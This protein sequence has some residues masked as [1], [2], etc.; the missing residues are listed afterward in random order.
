MKSFES[1]DL[2]KDL[3]RVR[4]FSGLV[5]KKI[6]ESNPNYEGKLQNLTKEE[7]EDLDKIL[8]MAEQILL[9]HQHK[10]EA[11]V[12]LK[13]FAGLLKNWTISLSEI[14]DQIQMM[15]ISVQSSVSEIKN[16][17]N[18]VSTNFSIDDSKKQPQ[19]LASNQ[20]TINLT[21][22]ATGVYPQG[23]QQNNPVQIE[24]VV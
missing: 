9:K 23:Y 1:T 13:E 10:K 6:L 24:Q 17:Q 18:D 5:K 19:T 15:L 20:G 2:E 12:L 16:A 4:Q 7:L 11:Y 3:K 14:N 21:K 22:S 8:G